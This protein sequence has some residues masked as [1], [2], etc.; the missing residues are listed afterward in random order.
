[1]KRKIGSLFHLRRRLADLSGW[2]WKLAWWRRGRWWSEAGRRRRWSDTVRG[3]T[4]GDVPT[5]SGR[6]CWPVPLD[7]WRRPARGPSCRQCCCDW[8]LTTNSW[9]R[10]PPWSDGQRLLVGPLHP[11][12]PSLQSRTSSS[13]RRDQSR[14]DLARSD[15]AAVVNLRPFDGRCMM[16][17]Q[18]IRP[19]A[20]VDYCCCMQ[21]ET[22]LFCSVVAE[23]QRW[24]LLDASPQLLQLHYLFIH[25]HSNKQKCSNL[26][27]ER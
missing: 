7:S 6:S 1:M 24:T 21:R 13:T 17:S 10:S 3:L 15:A 16:L 8:P 20:P 14:C 27:R 11:H 12:R 19:A 22:F 18:H 23:D 26:V 2:T 5:G 4:S 9:R 25:T